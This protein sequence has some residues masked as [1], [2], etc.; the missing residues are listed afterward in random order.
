M[1][2]EAVPGYAIPAFSDGIAMVLARY[3]CRA[4]VLI[5]AVRTFPKCNIMVVR[6]LRLDR[7]IWGSVHRISPEA[8]VPV[9]EIKT[10][11]TCLGGAANV[12]ANI[13]SLGGIPITLG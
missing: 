13:R 6:D 7:F 1:R 9:V 2:L 12:S 4:D 5:R 8:P 3:N 11:S 10:E